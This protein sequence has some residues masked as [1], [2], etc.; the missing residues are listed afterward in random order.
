M[1]SFI[2]GSTLCDLLTH[3]LNFKR[4]LLFVAFAG[5]GA[6]LSAR[7]YRLPT[8]SLTVSGSQVNEHVYDISILAS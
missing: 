7:R 4:K 8:T 2:L 5:W 1:V 6:R 3:L